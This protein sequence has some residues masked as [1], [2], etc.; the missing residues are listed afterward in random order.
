LFPEAFSGKEQPLPFGE[1][2]ALEGCFPGGRTTVSDLD[3][4]HDGSFSRNNVKLEMSDPD[5][6]SQNREPV[7][8]EVFDGGL[9]GA[10]SEGV[11]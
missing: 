9:L 2:Y 1:A 11:A 7:S 8:D 5:V 10:S 3:D 4:G 6:S